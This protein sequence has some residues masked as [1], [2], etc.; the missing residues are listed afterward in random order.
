M[1]IVIAVGFAPLLSK[2]FTVYVLS[3]RTPDHFYVGITQNFMSRLKNHRRGK[4]AKFTQ[5]HGV[6]KVLF[7]KKVRGEERAKD[8]AKLYTDHYIQICGERNVAGYA[9]SRAN[10]GD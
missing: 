8:L 6:E 5:T 7:T 9:H 3:C 4:G 10:W 2:P 1:V